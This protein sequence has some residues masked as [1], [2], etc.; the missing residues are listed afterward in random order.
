[1]SEIN[2]PKCYLAMPLIRD[3]IG[4]TVVCPECRHR[5]VMTDDAIPPVAYPSAPAPPQYRPQYNAPAPMPLNVPQMIPSVTVHNYN[6]HYKQI[7]SVGWFGRA[8][9]SSFGIMLGIF[10]FFAMCFMLTVVG[11]GILA[12]VGEAARQQHDSEYRTR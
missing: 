5:F 11:C 6:P 3:L 2:C 8:F 4:R 7:S 1:M 12:G 10:A 9:G